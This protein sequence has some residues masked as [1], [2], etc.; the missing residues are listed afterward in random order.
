M[1][2]VIGKTNASVQGIYEVDREKVSLLSPVTGQFVSLNYIIKINM[3][4]KEMQKSFEEGELHYHDIFDMVE[5]ALNLPT[6]RPDSIKRTPTNLPTRV[7]KTII[8][9]CRIHAIHTNAK[10]V[11]M[12]TST[13]HSEDTPTLVIKE[14]ETLVSPHYDSHVVEVVNQP[15]ESPLSGSYHLTLEKPYISQ[16]NKI[17][18]HLSFAAYVRAPPRGNAV[19]QAR[20]NIR[21][22]AS[23]Y[24]RSAAHKV[25]TLFR[26]S[27]KR[28]SETS[29]TKAPSGSIMDAVAKIL[30][31][32]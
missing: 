5:S 16:D 15:G 30:K 11:F 24:Q 31:Q 21:V 7:A 10:M 1:I 4:E 3:Y 8:Q 23:K 32:S 27:M 22:L 14:G 9:I 28:K 17:I 13:D 2:N 29:P 6:T 18:G 19:S 25:N 12:T 20:L 26:K